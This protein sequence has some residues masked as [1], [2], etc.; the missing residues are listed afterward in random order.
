[1]QM[2]ITLL[3]VRFDY[4]CA[5]HDAEM[6]AVKLHGK[7][8]NLLRKLRFEYDEVL[9]QVDVLLMPTLPW[10]AKKLLVSIVHVLL[11]SQLTRNVHQPANSSP[12]THFKDQNGL[13][14]SR[15]HVTRF[16]LDKSPFPGYEH[17]SVQPDRASRNHIPVRHAPAA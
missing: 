4:M 15:L 1:M 2:T 12:T 5:E 17:C 11:S 9:S 7:A 10:V 6:F 8:H 13:V 14:S 16:R 3:Y